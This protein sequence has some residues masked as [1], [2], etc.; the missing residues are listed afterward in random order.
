VV[1]TLNSMAAV[2]RQAPTKA[3]GFP[4]AGAHAT[5]AM[6][7]LG[8]PGWLAFSAPEAI[9]RAIRGH[10]AET[11]KPMAGNGNTMSQRPFPPASAPRVS[12]DLAC[13]PVA[14]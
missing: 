8:R 11:P 10:R 13:G 9:P 6:R 5:D 14:T 1:V 3:A 7:P 2:S 4:H 12:Q